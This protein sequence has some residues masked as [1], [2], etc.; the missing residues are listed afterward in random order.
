M[1][2]VAIYNG[3][4]TN[5]TDLSGIGGSSDNA[6]TTAANTAKENPKPTLTNVMSMSMPDNKQEAGLGAYPEENSMARNMQTATPMHS[7]MRG[8]GELPAKDRAVN[9]AKFGAG[10]GMQVGGMHGSMIG[11]AIGSFAGRGLGMAQSGEAEN[12]K[13]KGNV[14]NTLNALGTVNKQGVINFE[15]GEKFFVNP[16]PNFAL[17]NNSSVTG[18]PSRTI[19]EVDRTHPFSRR[20]TAVARPLAYFINSLTD[21]KD[22]SNPNDKK[23]IDDTTGLLVNALQQ[24]TD[25]ITQVYGRANELLKK[26]GVSSKGL[27][28][29]FDANKSKIPEEDAAIIKQGLNIL[30]AG[31]KNG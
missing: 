14:V 27:S 22:P 17:Q 5:S 29:Y 31:G 21:Y 28:S 16:D 24:N 12:I 11:A 4:N 6:G 15:D 3:G 8:L 26:F 2:N 10:I 20:T 1:G 18:K 13:R 7:A 9:G 23:I 19:F 30:S 25:N